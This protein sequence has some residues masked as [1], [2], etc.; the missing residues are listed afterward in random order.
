MS[1]IILPP[2]IIGFE[3]TL[4]PR[5]LFAFGPAGFDTITTF[6]DAKTFF[7]FGVGTVDASG[8]FTIA[9]MNAHSDTVFTTTL[10]PQ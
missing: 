5:R 8:Q 6:A 2:D 9:I 4:H 1:A 3:D 10:R 7:N